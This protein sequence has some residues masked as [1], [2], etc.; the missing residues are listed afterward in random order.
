M[1]SIQKFMKAGFLEAYCLGLLSAA[2]TESVFWAAKQN[3]ELEIKIKEIESALMAYSRL[4]VAP[5]L[6]QQILTTLVSLPDTNKIDI[7]N[8][9]VIDSNSDLEEWNEAVKD[10]LPENIFDGIKIHYLKNDSLG[11]LCIAWLENSLQEGEHHK[12]QFAESFF[13]LEGSCTCT[14]GG[15]IFNL[16]AGDYLEIPFDTNHTITNTSVGIPYV[17]ALIQR[18]RTAA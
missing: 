11:E 7:T 2:E 17:K 8:P 14:I 16:K 5:H 13:I 4:K 3:T 9:P 1:D 12:E 18:I 10:L 15:R 6:K